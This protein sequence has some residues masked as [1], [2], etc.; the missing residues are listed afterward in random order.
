MSKQFLNFGYIEI[1]KRKNN[2][3]KNYKIK[4]FYALQE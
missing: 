3:K 2:N 4:F 1:D